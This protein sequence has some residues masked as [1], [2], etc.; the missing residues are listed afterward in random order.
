MVPTPIGKG[1]PIPYTSSIQDDNRSSRSAIRTS[2]SAATGEYVISY[3]V[4]GAMNSFSDHDELFWNVDGALWPVSKA[5]VV[6]L[7]NFPSGAFQKAACYQGP[8]GSTETCSYA[9]TAMTADY[10]STRVLRSWRGDVDRH[11]PQQGRGR[12]SAP[13]AR[14][15]AAPVSPGRL[16]HQPSHR[17]CCGPRARRGHRLRGVELVGAWA[18]PRLPDAVLPDSRSTR[19]CGAARRPRAIAVEF[20]PPRTCGRP[21][22]G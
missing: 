19:T 13:D 2:W 22:S 5:N 1:N 21:S 12:G 9:S 11:R 3:T 18:R 20:G 6:A 17:R 4:V 7:V 16:R 8:P 10:Q 15:E 14:T